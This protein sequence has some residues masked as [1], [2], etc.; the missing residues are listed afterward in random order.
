VRF[1][2]PSPCSPKREPDARD[3]HACGKPIQPE[4]LEE[5]AAKALAA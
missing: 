3:G 5:A 2:A 1:A 4:Q